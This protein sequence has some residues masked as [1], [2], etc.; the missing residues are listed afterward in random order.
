[1]FIE[2]YNTNISSRRPRYKSA[3]TALT[4][5]L[6][7]PL[8][9]VPMICVRQFRCTWLAATKFCMTIR[10]TLFQLWPADLE[11]RDDVD[12]GLCVQPREVAQPA[13]LDIAH[14]LDRGAACSS[15]CVAH[16]GRRW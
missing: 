3:R 6:L 11:V 10:L 15:V 12:L 13:V 8:K 7:P 4:Y 14:A 16:G 9:T 2:F 5:S 1:M